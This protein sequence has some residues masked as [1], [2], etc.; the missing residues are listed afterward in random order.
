MLSRK[1]IKLSDYIEYPFLI[2]SIYLDFNIG[3]DYV[4]VHSSMLIEPKLKESR[5][6]EITN[7]SKKSTGKWKFYKLQ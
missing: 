3:N 2:P 1:T 6:K 7:V 5:L 4:V